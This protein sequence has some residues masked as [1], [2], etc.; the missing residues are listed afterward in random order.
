MTLTSPI[1]ADIALDVAYLAD[2]INRTCKQRKLNGHDFQEAVLLLCYRLIN[3]CPINEPGAVND[4]DRLCQLTLITFLTTLL[5]E[6]GRN[7]ARYN[8]LSGNLGTTMRQTTCLGTNASFVLWCIFVG[9]IAV[10]NADDDQWMWPLL[11]RICQQCELSSWAEVRDI[12]IS[13][14]WIKPIHDKPGKALWE[15]FTDSSK[16]LPSGDRPTT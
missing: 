3:F 4:L 5:L 7:P 13:F 15:T 9:G 14:A 8:L 1:L 16:G 6:Y 2:L 11:S 12:L 10:F